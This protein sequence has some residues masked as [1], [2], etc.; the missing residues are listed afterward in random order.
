MQRD[1]ELIRAILLDVEQRPPNRH[2]IDRLSIEGYDAD[3]IIEHVEMLLDGKILEGLLSA[4]WD[5]RRRIGGFAISTITWQGREFV[6]ALRNESVWA[7]TKK[8]LVEKGGDAP[9]SIVIS[10]AAE[11]AKK[12]FIGG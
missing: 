5:G 1:M 6:D 9:F 4:D 7:K 3:A 8:Y 10:V 11:I 2:P 12:H